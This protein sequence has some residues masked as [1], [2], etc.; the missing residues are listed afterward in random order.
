ME[1]YIDRMLKKMGFTVNHTAKSI[2]IDVWGVNTY[3]TYELDYDTY[4]KMSANE[5]LN[6]GDIITDIDKLI[7][8]E[9]GYY[10]YTSTTPL[11]DEFEKTNDY[12]KLSCCDLRCI[13][14]TWEMEET[15]I[16]AS[17]DSL[18]DDIEA[19]IFDL[20]WRTFTSQNFDELLDEIFVSGGSN[21]IE[22]SSKYSSIKTYGLTKDDEFEAVDSYIKKLMDSGELALPNFEAW[23]EEFAL[24]LGEKYGEDIFDDNEDEE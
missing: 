17:F 18:K 12:D 6:M 24:T 23:E 9:E 4:D 20:S 3:V 5:A 8:A 21:H 22:V 7:W 13:A 14:N 11:L 10:I 16:R 19:A 15:A 1:N 2:T